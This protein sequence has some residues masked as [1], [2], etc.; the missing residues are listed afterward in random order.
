[1]DTITSFYPTFDGNGNVTEYLKWVQD[2]DPVTPGDQ[3]DAIVAAHFE[4]DAFGNL[5]VDT[6][7]KA[8]LFPFRFSTKPQDS[9]TGLYY[10]GY[11]WYDPLTG[12]WPSR[13]PIGERG[14][15]NLY[16]FVGND[17]VDWVDV[18]GLIIATQED[19]IYRDSVAN[20]LMKLCCPIKVKWK[21]LSRSDRYD[22]ELIPTGRSDYS[23]Q[24]FDDSSDW[25]VLIWDGDPNQGDSK[26][27]KEIFAH[28]DAATFHGKNRSKE[29]AAG[30]THFVYLTRYIYGTNTDG[31]FER[32]ELLNDSEANAEGDMRRITVSPNASLNLSLDPNKKGAP[33]EE[34]TPKSYSL[35]N[36]SLS[37][38]NEFCAALWHELKGHVIDNYD[39]HSTKPWNDAS[40]AGKKPP[41]KEWGRSDDAIEDENWAR[42]ALG[43]P[44]RRPQYF[45]TP[46]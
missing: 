3:S 31:K 33:Q 21:L 32:K 16:G 30:K 38:P 34:P 12:R 24:T 39:K 6:Y 4:Y 27:P 45:P 9:V 36:V 15:V 20:C 10:Y 7:S 13:D 44:L 19:K 37:N 17:G 35:Q 11:R 22:R 43:L 46:K 41:V 8:S 29:L 40:N 23:Q 26:C 28:L 5:V 42:T 1:V 18:V 14:G 2:S 25:Y